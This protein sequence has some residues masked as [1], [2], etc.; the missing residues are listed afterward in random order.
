[1]ANDSI[2]IEVEFEDGR[3][4]FATFRKSVESQAEPVGKNIGI[5]IGNGI[6]TSLKVAGAA[7]AATLAAAAAVIPKA[8][9][10]ATESENAINRLNVALASAGQFSESASARLQT[11]AKDLS[12]STGLAGEAVVE[13]IA[14]IQNLTKIG[15]AGL[16]RVTRATADLASALK[17]DL[18]SAGQLVARAL[19]GNVG[20]L[21][22]YG[23]VVEKSTTDSERFANVLR[24][25]EGTFGG[26]AIA[27]ATTFTG[28]LNRLSEAFNDI[29]E[30]IGNLIIKSPTLRALLVETG[31]ALI[32]VQEAIASIGKQGDVFAPIIAGLIN[33]GAVLNAG[34]V[35]PLEVAFNIA[36]AL[37]ST[38]QLVGQTILSVFVGAT[39][40]IVGILATIFEKITGIG[41]AI[42][43]GALGLA[44]RQFELLG[45]FTGKAIDDFKNLFDFDITTG[46]NDFLAKGLD[47]AARAPEIGQNIKNGIAP[48]LQ[49]VTSE[50]QK[51]IDEL[52]KLGFSF[53]QL[54]GKTAKELSELLENAKG[55]ANATR[56]LFTSV[57]STTFQQLG[58]SLVKGQGAFATFQSTILNL[59]GDFAIQVGLLVIG[60]G[61]AAQAVAAALTNFFTGPLA[62][63]AGVA[64]IA[65]GGALK[66]LAGGPAAA[67]GA[68]A[69]GGG[70]GLTS[71][72]PETS[73]EEPV[74]GDPRNRATEVTLIVQGN[75]LNTRD[76]GLEIASTLQNFFDTND[77]VLVR[78]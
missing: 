65:L 62:I 32:R 15:P 58:A 63:A 70:G 3:K 48:N 68:G 77:G 51:L 13:T 1:M 9:R 42:A 57:I 16:E 17:I 6:T 76:S 54:K 10:E 22:R 30:E 78:S 5:S 21:R 40:A 73:Q 38:L 19:E 45:V 8:L 18:E 7:I 69:G 53:E 31:N 67:A 55:I 71:A 52:L 34:V 46:I 47:L 60:I 56:T 61:T 43:D 64:L 49:T 23:L 35:A 4:G 24:A 27:N 20:A 14:Q 12:Q 28:A 2:V 37:I 29:F 33:F 11:F 59:L 26:Q 66:A 50:V 44:K 74:F 75:I 25:I 39:S 72:P 36:K 41:K